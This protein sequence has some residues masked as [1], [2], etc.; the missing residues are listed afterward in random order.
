MKQ[1]LVCMDFRQKI[2][3]GVVLVSVFIF[4][5]TVLVFVYVLSAKGE[6]VPDL[7]KPFI[8][9]H[10]HFMVIMGLFGVVSG[11]VVYSMMSSTI[12]RERK[13]A[14][15]NVEIIMKFLG[16]DD[17]QIVRLLLEKD[18]ATTQSNISAQPGM[19]RLKAHR[20]VR[21]LEDRGIIHVEK[22]GKVNMIRLV[23]ELRQIKA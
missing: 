23:D 12:E 19:T 22:H 4:L 13:M 6:A 8:E 21:K 15:T 2:V 5:V 9:H 11:I 1:Y 16:D 3:L 14:K 17:R 10:V 7:F 20:V 18:G